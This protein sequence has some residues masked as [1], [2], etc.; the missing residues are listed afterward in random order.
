M[1]ISAREYAKR[2]GKCDKTIYRM[3]RAGILKARKVGRDWEIDIAGSERSLNLKFGN[4]LEK[5]MTKK[6]LCLKSP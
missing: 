6:N 1:R 5:E 2:E 4:S 3:C